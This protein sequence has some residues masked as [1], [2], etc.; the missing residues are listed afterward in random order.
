MS[1]KG[2][3][4]GFVTPYLSKSSDYIKLMSNE[5]I[6]V[7]LKSS[8]VELFSRYIHI[9]KH[10]G[11]NCVICS[12]RKALQIGMTHNWQYLDHILEQ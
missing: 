5:E 7:Q 10:F 6:T 3:V 12:I 9:Y 4:D 8:S 11:S 2:N 1:R